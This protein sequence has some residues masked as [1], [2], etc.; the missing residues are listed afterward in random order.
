MLDKYNRF[1]W[2]HLESQETRG[3]KGPRSEGYCSYAWQEK[4]KEFGGKDARSCQCDHCCCLRKGPFWQSVD[5]FLNESPD[6]IEIRG[7]NIA[8]IT[9]FSLAQ[10]DFTSFVSVVA[11]RMEFVP[12]VPDHAAAGMRYPACLSQHV[13][14]NTRSCFLMKKLLHVLRNWSTFQIISIL[15]ILGP[16]KLYPW[17]FPI[18]MPS[19]LWDCVFLFIA[20]FMPLLAQKR[21]SSATLV[22]GTHEGSDCKSFICA[23]G[24]FQKVC[25]HI[26]TWFEWSC[27]CPFLEVLECCVLQQ[28][29]SLPCL[30]PHSQQRRRDMLPSEICGDF[31]DFRLRPRDR[32]SPLQVCYASCGALTASIQAGSPAGVSHIA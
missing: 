24:V 31:S 6:G 4:Q 18:F 19:S 10:A 32:K 3:Q 22:H 28:H 1:N 2:D 8:G 29:F 15:R 14:M 20:N 5:C 27:Y 30:F 12:L 7:E 25:Q 16:L 17:Y 23:E 11:W 13:S 26:D 9:F 21:S